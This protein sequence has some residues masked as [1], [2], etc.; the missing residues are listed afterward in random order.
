MVLWV[1]GSM[2]IGLFAVASCGS[3]DTPAPSPAPP[4]ATGAPDGSASDGA[5]GSS[6]GGVDSGGDATTP[7]F[8]S[9][10]EYYTANPEGVPPDGIAFCL[11][12]ASSHQP[13]NCCVRDSQC[14][15]VGGRCCPYGSGGCGGRASCECY[16]P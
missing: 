3:P 7:E 13:G 8:G 14:S 2:A 10:L 4:A 15:D 5:A 9:C 12:D 16:T 6:E 1:V 11:D